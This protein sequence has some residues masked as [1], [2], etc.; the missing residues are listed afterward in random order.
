MEAGVPSSTV[1]TFTDPDAYHAAI[2]HTHAEGIVTGRGQFRAEL[3]LVRLNR[4]S[5]HRG[6]EALPRLTYSAVDPAL[7]LIAFPVH[8]DQQLYVG[9]LEMV[10]GDIFAFR[11]GTESYNRM[12]AGCR[13]GTIFLTHE[14]IAAAAEAIVARELT[15]PPVTH[16]IMP[17]PGV[18]NR[19][20]N[21][22]EAAGHLAKTAPDILVKPE[23]ARA[24]DQAV[25]EAMVGCLASDESMIGMLIA[26]MRK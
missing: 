5:L 16:R 6:E 12:A 21:L 22:H 15:A 9:G 23:V 8:R 4:V 7:F 2:R 18:L 3:T 19:L 24:M 10:H 13:W 20:L 11:A 14:D 25:V 17:P 26:N 1:S